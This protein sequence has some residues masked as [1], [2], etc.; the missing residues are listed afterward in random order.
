VKACLTKTKQYIFAFARKL[1]I[2]VRLSKNILTRI[3][4]PRFEAENVQLKRLKKLRKGGALR[5]AWFS[6]PRAKARTSPAQRVF[7]YLSCCRFPRMAKAMMRY[8]NVST[9]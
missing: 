5:Q 3:F 1:N 2:K 6:C 8:A 7:I 4:L 9:P